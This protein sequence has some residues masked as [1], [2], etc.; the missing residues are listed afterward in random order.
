MMAAV[1]VEMASQT[2]D[3]Q[4]EGSPGNP[5]MKEFRAQLKIDIESESASDARK[6]L[7]PWS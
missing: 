4:E 3:D 7:L 6:G 5:V 2:A 1:M